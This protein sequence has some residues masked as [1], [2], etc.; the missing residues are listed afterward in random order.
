MNKNKKIS[1]VAAIVQIILTILFFAAYPALNAAV[2]EKYYYTS[3]YA[4]MAF[5]WITPLVL[6]VIMNLGRILSTVKA[7][8]RSVDLY[9]ALAAGILAVF[10]IAGLLIKI[11]RVMFTVLDINGSA[12]GA[13]A[14]LFFWCMVLNIIKPCD[15]EK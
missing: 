6:A 9:C 13:L 12:L 11:P 1:R 3:P 2:K 4:M 15:A 14:M 5:Y 10:C 8:K 7:E